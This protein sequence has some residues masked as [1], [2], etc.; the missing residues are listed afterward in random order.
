[1]ATTYLNLNYHIVTATKDRQPSIGSSW[2]PRFHEYLGG[3]IRGLEAVP[4][5]IGGVADHIHVLVGLRATHRLS[6]FVREMKK[7]SASWAT[8]HGDPAF[9]WQES[10]AAFTVGTSQLEAVRAYV[11]NQEQHHARRSSAEE[12]EDFLRRAGVAYDPKYF[13]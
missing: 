3:T 9:K 2:R 6:D 5:A 7:A 4:L 8:Q 1:M 10:Y 11:L 12:L 13:E